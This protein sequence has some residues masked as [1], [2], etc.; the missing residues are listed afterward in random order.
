MNIDKPQYLYL[1]IINHSIRKT[2][3]IFQLILVLT[4]S[5]LLFACEPELDLI[6]CTPMVDFEQVIE[7]EPKQGRFLDGIYYSPYRKAIMVQMNEEKGTYDLYRIVLKDQSNQQIDGGY[8]WWY[9]SKIP[10]EKDH[11]RLYEIPSDIACIK[12]IYISFDAQRNGDSD[13]INITEIEVDVF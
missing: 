10:L 4:L 3:F 11:Y 9:A 13:Y 8:I 6:L 2:S 5:T 1:G 7:H 12:K